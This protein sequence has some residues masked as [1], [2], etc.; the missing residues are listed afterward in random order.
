[1][2]VDRLLR[3]RILL[4]RELSKLKKSLR[5]HFIRTRF[6]ALLTDPNLR[7]PEVEDELLDSKEAYIIDLLSG[8]MGQ[9]VEAVGK[10]WEKLKQED[11]LPHTPANKY[12]Q[13]LSES[14]IDEML[15]YCYITDVA[16]FK[17]KV[18]GFRKRL[19]CFIVWRAA[20]A[21]VSLVQD[22]SSKFKTLHRIVDRR[23]RTVERML[24]SVGYK[25]WESEGW[26]RIFD[27]PTLGMPGTEVNVPAEL[28]WDEW[29][30]DMEK[31]HALVAVADVEEAIEALFIPQPY[32]DARNRL[33]C[34]HVIHALHLE[35]LLFVKKKHN[36]K[37]RDLYA[38][39]GKKYV[40]IASSWFDDLT[41][42][43]T[44]DTLDGEKIPKFFQAVNVEERDLQPGDQ[45][46]I[47]N[48]PVFIHVLGE[49]FRV[50][51]N[52]IVV[53][54]D[55]S[56][57]AYMGLGYQ[58]NSLLRMKQELFAAL[59]DALKD[60]RDT[61]KR[62][63]PEEMK[64]IVKP[65]LFIRRFWAGDVPAPP[66][67]T[68]ASEYNYAEWWLEWRVE[69]LKFT[70]AQYM[71]LEMMILK[72]ATEIPKVRN[73]IWD[74]L[75]VKYKKDEDQNPDATKWT[76]YGYFPLWVPRLYGGEIRLNERGEIKNIQ[77][78][79][80]RLGKTKPPPDIYANIGVLGWNLFKAIQPIEPDEE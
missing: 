53:Q 64:Y 62:I 30:G 18:K 70:T 31:P 55:P 68:Y 71:T 47:W 32:S 80:V 66:D 45:V 74:Y 36:K 28:Y 9:V 4:P 41:N 75:N 26:E 37:T 51:E 57:K 22:V 65:H 44:P 61:A 38:L 79:E 60:I 67:W 21:D 78:T 25:D 12:H 34:D 43:R 20:A 6:R 49:D 10:I 77:E 27:Y 46:K 33:L 48:H 3:D 69:A 5:E 1:M 63:P 59:K 35:A 56:P 13:H 58:P 73:F 23:I 52:V 16:D 72:Q 29:S 42:G 40:A 2:K 11:Q 50:N 7:D 14:E 15:L 76:G 24:Y 54:T 19:A 39:A 8:E 17:A